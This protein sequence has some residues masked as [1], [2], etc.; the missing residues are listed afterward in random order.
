MKPPRCKHKWGPWQR[1]T[2]GETFTP[3]GRVFLPSGEYRFCIKWCGDYE[4]KSKGG[5]VSRETIGVR[6]DPTVKKGERT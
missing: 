5:K 2:Q 4:K 6:H 1:V 3:A